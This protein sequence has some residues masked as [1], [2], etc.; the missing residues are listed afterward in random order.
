MKK[1]TKDSIRNRYASIATSERTGCGCAPSSCCGESP[2]GQTPGEELG[3]SQDDLQAVPDGANLGLGCGNPQAI[4]QLEPGETVVDLG[5]GAGFD[6]FLATRKVGENGTVYGIDMTQEMV[7]K[8][9]RN[10]ER[11]RMTNVTF[12]LGEIE[13]I[14]LPDDVADVV[15]SNCVINLSLD[16]QKVFAEAYRILKPGGR[17]AVSDIVTIG[18]LPQAM[19][20][21]PLL[22]SACIAGASSRDD[23]IR[24]MEQAGFEHI[25]VVPKDESK[26]FIA[27]WAPGSKAEQYIV[28]AEIA[29]RKRSI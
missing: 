19:R 25:A 8:A 17:L 14:P 15:I 18:N 21:D 12:I 22:H 10:A 3:Y 28:S 2:F 24:M 9:Q 1:V 27:N 5:S 4:A 11:A 23:V 13:D 7:E 29:G 26:E 20:D 6:C 16:K